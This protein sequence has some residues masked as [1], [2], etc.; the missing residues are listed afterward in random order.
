MIILPKRTDFMVAGALLSC[1]GRTSAETH[2][3]SMR[4][5]DANLSSQ[6]NVFDPQVLRVQPGDSVKFKAIDTGH[7]SASKKGMIPEG[8]AHWNGAVDEEIEMTFEQDGTY[9]YLCLPQYEMGMVG[10]ILVG[11]YTANLAEAKRVRHPGKA[12]AAFGALF[13]LIEQS[14]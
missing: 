4:N 9:G 14:L 6:I 12:K 8:A 5:A 7:N 13:D 1:A 2:I 3:V 10:L 11:D